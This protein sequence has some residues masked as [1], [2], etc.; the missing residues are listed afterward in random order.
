MNAGHR[1]WFLGGVVAAVSAAGLTGCSAYKAPLFEVIAIEETAR[2]DEALLL[3]FVLTAENRNDRD[4][5]LEQARYR[6]SL[7]GQRVFS[8]RR[9]AEAVV[10]RFGKQTIELPAVVPADQFDLARFDAASELRYT[11]TGSVEYQTPG[12]LA[13]VLFDT[14]VRRPKAGLN[15]S[16]MISLSP[17]TGAASPAPAAEVSSAGERGE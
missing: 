2:S 5:P 3:T 4:L 7:D 12:E 16:G 17:P 11:L 8:G 6:L 13:E 1:A 9:S 14:G 15:A 10:R